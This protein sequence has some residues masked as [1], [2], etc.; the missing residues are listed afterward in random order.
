MYAL[1]DGNNFFVS[2]E[3]VFQPKYDDKPTLVLS[4][5][6]GCVIA[7]STEVK[8]LGI[9]MG[10]PYFKV[11]ELC[12]KEK[13]KVF[14]SNFRLYGDMSS[15]MMSV[16]SEGAL[17]LH[18]YS[19]DEAFLEL[20]TAPLPSLE[21]DMREL[22][23]RVKQLTGLP[24]SIGIAPTKTLAKAAN[25][26]AKKHSETSGVYTFHEGNREALLSE[27]DVGDLWGIGHNLKY[28]LEKMGIKTGLDLARS[29]PTFMRRRFN[30]HMERLVMEI[31]GIP[32]FSLEEGMAMHPTIQATRSFGRPVME[33]SELEEA[34]AT[35]TTRASV[36]LRERGMQARAVLVY[37]KT[38]PHKLH[39]PQYAKSHLVTLPHA[40]SDTTLLISYALKALRAVYKTGFAYKKAG[41]WLNELME[42]TS[43]QEELFSV[44]DTVET[45]K[46]MISL[47]RLNKRFGQ[48]AVQTATCGVKPKWTMRSEQRSLDYTTRW[49]D[50]I[51]AK[52]E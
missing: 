51:Q 39:L 4:N 34:V 13:I 27:M 18:P 28:T 36:K 50:I 23:T 3:R 35:Y 16:L 8:E 5:N 10:A 31:R 19:I 52:T 24:V 33:L 46:L 26:Y 32:C 2:C 15:R 42:G 1:A 6:D 49:S 9:P 14:S 29:D 48:G 20:R 44:G 22:K 40:T 17:A 21:H 41:V 47:D 25:N 7:R 11:K 43:Y 37:I 12:A 45:Q 38:N 30:V